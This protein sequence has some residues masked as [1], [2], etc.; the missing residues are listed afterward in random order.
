MAD[1][2]NIDGN[3]LI[4]AKVVPKDSSDPSDVAT[5]DAITEGELAC[6]GD[7]LP[8]PKFVFFYANGGIAE[9]LVLVVLAAILARKH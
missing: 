6:I 7:D 4:N 8:L 5:I 3:H 1:V 2:I 9:T